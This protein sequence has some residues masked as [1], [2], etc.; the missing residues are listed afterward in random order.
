LEDYD[1]KEAAFMRHYGILIPQEWPYYHFENHV[2]LL[3]ELI[4][5][6]QQDSEGTGQ[7][8]TLENMKADA[9]KMMTNAQKQ[10]PKITVPKIKP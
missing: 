7:G 6:Q 5:K 1:I 9:N 2:K 10:L 4:E 3:R 8:M